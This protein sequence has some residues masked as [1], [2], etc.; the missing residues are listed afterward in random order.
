MFHPSLLLLFLDGHF[1]TNPDLDD[2]TDVSVH[3]FLP[4]FPDLKAQVKRT[5]P[6]DALFGN[7]AKF[8]PP[9]ESTSSQEEEEKEDGIEYIKRSVK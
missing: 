3:D 2:L 7:L 9:T 5:P 6:E 4:N 1:E 8:L